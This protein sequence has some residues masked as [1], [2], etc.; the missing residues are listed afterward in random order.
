MSVEVF[1]VEDLKNIQSAVAQMLKGLGD[2]R[3]TAAVSTEAEA[4]GWLEQ[5]PGSWDLAVIDLVLE[6]G[7]GMGAISRARRTSPKG[8]VVVF[9]NF[10]TPGIKAHCLRL[11]ADAAFDKHSELRDF[12]DYCAELAAPERSLPS[13]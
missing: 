12:A 10:V 2:F 13:A 5:N 9:S 6:Q 7:S 1:L 8:R 3:I 4:L 11:G